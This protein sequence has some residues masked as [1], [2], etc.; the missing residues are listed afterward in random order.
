M[1]TATKALGLILVASCFGLGCGDEEEDRSDNPIM[2]QTN[3]TQTG[4]AP[5]GPTQTNTTQIGTTQTNTLI[6]SNTSTGTSTNTSTSTST[7]E[8]RTLCSAT[9]GCLGRREACLDDPSGAAFC[10]EPTSCKDVLDAVEDQYC[11]G[12]ATGT[13]CLPS[14]TDGSMFVC[15]APDMVT[16]KEARYVRIV[17]T[18]PNCTRTD[19]NGQSD[20]G[21]DIAI[22]ELL[23]NG[24]A[25]GYAKLPAASAYSPGAG[26]PGYTDTSRVFDGAPKAKGPRGCPEEDV[27]GRYFRSGTV[28]SLG[29][30]GSV[31]LEF[32]NNGSNLLLTNGAEIAVVELG[33]YC[34]PQNDMNDYGTDRYRVDVCQTDVGAMFS[35]VDFNASCTTVSG[36]TEQGPTNVVVNGL[37]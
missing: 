19:V 5:S 1:N 4:T 16:K 21:S 9:Q 20:A 32:E 12:Q 23:S 28:V 2:M 36:N 30:G 31:V 17:D 18:T 35:D 34:E 24:T 8:D 14:L 11:E 7:S 6:L 26:S 25:L 13:K 29:C 22:V 15:R 3:T 10:G 33:R 27:E 37:P